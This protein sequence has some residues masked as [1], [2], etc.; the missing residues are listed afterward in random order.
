MLTYLQTYFPGD[1]FT[2]K[3]IEFLENDLEKYN[4]TH[5]WE[6]LNYTYTQEQLFQ[7]LIKII[8][9]TTENK[10]PYYQ[11][12]FYRE[13]FDKLRNFMS[14]IPHKT[15]KTL[16]TFNQ[17]AQLCPEM[18]ETDNNSKQKIQEEYYRLS[19]TFKGI[20]QATKGFKKGQVVTIGG[21]TGLGKTS[22]VYNLLIDIT[23]IK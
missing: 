4:P 7:Q 14:L 9:P 20:N 8:R 3:T 2:N 11:H 21:Y 1:N 22:F 19:E 18:F 10:D 17:M 13:V 15:D 16:F 23:K 6:R 12:L 5:L